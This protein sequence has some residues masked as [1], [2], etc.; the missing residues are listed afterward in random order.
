MW[1]LDANSQG[2]L[3]RRAAFV[4]RSDPATESRLQKDVSQALQGMELS[5][6]EEYRC[7]K[8]EYSI[9]IHVRLGRGISAEEGLAVE[10]DGSFLFLACSAPTGSTRII[11]RHVELLGYNL[12]SVP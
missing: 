8:S 10:V 5:V 6:E 12:V 1:C 3:T 2:C 9:D 11:R 7:P 4:E